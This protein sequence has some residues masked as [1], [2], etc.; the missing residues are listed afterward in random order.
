MD[1]QRI[2][3]LRRPFVG[4][5]EGLKSN[6][7]TDLRGRLAPTCATDYVLPKDICWCVYAFPEFS[8]SMMVQCV[9]CFSMFFSESESEMLR[10]V[11][12][13]LAF[14]RRFAASG[15]VVMFVTFADDWPGGHKSV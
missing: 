14:F 8:M 10:R 11:G 1:M 9:R 12:D 15:K 4:S 5:R 7:A 6:Y 3:E 13:F 2:C